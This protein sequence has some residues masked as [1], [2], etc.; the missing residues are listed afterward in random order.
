MLLDVFLLDVRR[1]PQGDS[2]G[3]SKDPSTKW[4]MRHGSMFSL[5]VVVL[6]FASLLSRSGKTL[7]AR[8]P[9]YYVV[10]LPLVSSRNP[11]P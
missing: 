7:C 1:V 5:P 4:A 10:Y 3:R 11:F 8:A 9:I 6:L 2:N